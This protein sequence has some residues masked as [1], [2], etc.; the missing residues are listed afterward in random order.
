MCCVCAG[1]SVRCDGCVLV[2]TPQNLAVG[3]VRRQVTFCRR[4]GLTLLG[5]V[6]NMSGFVCPHCSVGGGLGGTGRQPAWYGRHAARLCRCRL[7]SCS[8]S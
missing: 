5:I 2:T 8:V 3:D 4:T 6:E 7:A 1:R